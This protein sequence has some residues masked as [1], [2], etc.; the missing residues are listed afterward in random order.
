MNTAQDWSLVMSLEGRCLTDWLVLLTNK[1]SRCPFIFSVNMDCLCQNYNS[2][3][4]TGLLNLDWSNYAPQHTALGQN[5]IQSKLDLAS[6]SS[7]I[8]LVK[9][10][11]DPNN[12][13]IL[14]SNTCCMWLSYELANLLGSWSCTDPDVCFCVCGEPWIARV[15]H[16]ST[17]VALARSK[18]LVTKDTTCGSWKPRTGICLICIKLISLE[19]DSYDLLKSKM[20]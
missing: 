16:G 3:A 9:S 8:I 15:H 10:K 11:K 13:T 12:P 2:I 17:L 19:R 6:K 18:Y 20:P 5:S 4:M 7:H 14:T 1:T